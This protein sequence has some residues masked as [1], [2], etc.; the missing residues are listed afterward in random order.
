MALGRAIHLVPF[1]FRIPASIFIKKVNWAQMA[2]RINICDKVVM[3]QA[4]TKT[5]LRFLPYIRQAP[6][7]TPIHSSVLRDL[8]EPTFTPFRIYGE[9]RE[10]PEEW[11]KKY[12]MK[13]WYLYLTHDGRK[14]KGL[15]IKINNFRRTKRIFLVR[16]LR[17]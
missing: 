10:D 5:S 1:C 17:S 15:K 13:C 4:R 16:D 14:L 6:G 7:P 8:N 3:A 9:A 2:D 11:K 12:C